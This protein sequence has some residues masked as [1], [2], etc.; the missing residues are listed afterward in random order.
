MTSTVQNPAQVCNLALAK[1]GAKMR[2]ASLYDGSEAAKKSLDIYGQTRDHVLYAGDWDFCQRAI[3][4]VLLKK[5]P[6]IP[7][8]YIATPWTTAYPATPWAYSYAYPA[9]CIKVRSIKRLPSFFPNWDPRYQRWSVDNDPGPQTVPGYAPPQKVILTQVPNAILVYTAQV[10]DPL[11]WN[12]AFLEVLTDALAEQLGPLLMGPEAFKI[13]QA[14][15][16]KDV[17]VAAVNKQRG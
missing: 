4:A 10:T 17:G 2:I 6:T 16:G 8:N 1:I 9:D 12:A 14:E 15:E 5:A 3:Q 7:P 13:A 11:Q